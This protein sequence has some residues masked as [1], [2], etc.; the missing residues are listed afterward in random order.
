[1]K[2]VKVAAA[3]IR[4]GDRVFATQRGYGDCKDAWEFPGGK[5]E[6]GETA[7]Q[8]L[9]RE[10]REELDCVIEL[11]ARIASVEYDY[12][13]FHLRMDCFWARAAGAL[14]LKEHEAARW[15]SPAELESVDWLPADRSLIPLLRAALGGGEAEPDASAARSAEAERETPEGHEPITAELICMAEHSPA[16]KALLEQ[17]VR[18]AA[19][20]NP[21]PDANPV[22]D[23]PGYYRFLDHCARCMPWEICPSE[24]NV[25]LFSR[26]DQSM[27]CLYFICEQPLAALAGRGYYH[28]SL[29]YHEPFRSWWIRFLS[30]SGAWLDTEESWCEAYYRTALA[31][32]DFH[33]Q[34]GTYEA[35][36]RWRSFNDFFTRRLKDPGRRPIFAPEDGD[37]VVSPADAV[38][39]GVWRIDDGSRVVG[40]EPAERYGIPIKTGSLKAIPALLRG[41]RYAEAFRGGTMTHTLL[42]VYDYHRY[43]APV[44]GTVRELLLLPQDDAPGG[45]ILWDPAAGR[46]R[47]DCDGS[48]GWQS[49]ETRGAVVIETDG[50]G[51]AA[52]VPVGMCQVCSVNFEPGVVPGARLKKGDPLGWF[53]FGGS[54]IVM[55]FSRELGFEPVAK[56]G[57]HLQMGRPYGVLTRKADGGKRK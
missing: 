3:V 5:L 24:K 12:P 36:E 25:S 7:E 40:A 33:L 41:S 2:T 42:E 52:V 43:H 30:V 18:Q 39:Q 20:L 27:G 54:D 9:V 47:I 29:V 46:Y 48:Y 22:R 14:V 10:I 15:L 32:P 45:V 38:P 51:L 19:E 37:L 16:L 50:G 6:P 53:A 11:G 4:D 28:N 13:D 23:L 1:M 8:A 57:E 31:N 17:A 34:D 21:D 49:I 55:L 56:P 26:L 44:S 35:P